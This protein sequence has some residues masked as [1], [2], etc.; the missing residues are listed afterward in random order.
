MKNYF[1][2]DSAAR[3]DEKILALRMKHN[4]EGYGLYWAIVEKL[5]EATDYKLTTDYNLIAYDLR[6]SS[7]VIKSIITDFGL[8]AFSDDEE[9]K[10]FYSESLMR[11]MDIKDSKSKQARR[12]AQ[13]RW[14]GKDKPSKEDVNADALQPN[15][16][17]NARKVKESKVKEI[18]LSNGETKVIAESLIKTMDIL[19]ADMIWLEPI[20]MNNHTPIAEMQDYIKLFFVELQSREDYIKTEKDAKDHFSKWLVIQIEKKQPKQKGG[21]NGTTTRNAH[22]GANAKP[23]K[24]ASKDYTTRF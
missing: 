22:N 21:N 9:G 19:L 1:S 20:C 14:K 7:G 23:A 16:D 11:R 15:S 8:F 24:E 10:R 6:V 18:S 3:D 12:A 5:R 13:T 2:H 17:S 4:W